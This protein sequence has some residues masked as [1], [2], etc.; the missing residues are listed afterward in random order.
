MTDA[1]LY[2]AVERVQASIHANLDDQCSAAARLAP[3]LQPDLRD[4]LDSIAT[5]HFRRDLTPQQARGAL[6]TTLAAMNS[7][8]ARLEQII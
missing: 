4:I 3:M 6:L 7:A 1:S 5:K 2:L 8:I